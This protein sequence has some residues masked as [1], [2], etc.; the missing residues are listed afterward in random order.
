MA[1]F[2]SQ[3]RKN[4]F[5]GKKGRGRKP[6]A[7]VQ[8]EES[9]FSRVRLLNVEEGE[10]F[11]LVTQLMGTN[12]IRGICQDGQER[13]FR[14]PGKLLK[15]VWIRENDVVIIRV[16]DFQP[17]KADVVWRFMGNQIEWL[18]R[19]GKLKGLPI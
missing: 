11:A 13:Q 14:I 8:T 2:N 7:P 4:S 12:Q 15:K 10:Q 3:K 6:G 17:S 9:F 16:W 5:S 18:K 19:N 1:N